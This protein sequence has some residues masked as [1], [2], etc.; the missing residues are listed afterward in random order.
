MKC[1]HFRTTN[2]CSQGFGIENDDCFFE[3]WKSIYKGEI[4]MGEII[5]FTKINDVDDVLIRES[6]G[7]Y[8]VEVR[9]NLCTKKILPFDKDYDA[10]E[11]FYNSIT[12][13]Y[14]DE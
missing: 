8:N 6:N 2:K 1:I 10:A 11:K 5:A 14:G 9:S 4:V 13:E 3:D 12:S 7:R